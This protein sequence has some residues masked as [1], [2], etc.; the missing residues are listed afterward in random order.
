MPDLKILTEAELDCK[1]TGMPDQ[2]I[3]ERA[4]LRVAHAA[5]GSRGG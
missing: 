1:T 4:L 5:A 3:C 2:A